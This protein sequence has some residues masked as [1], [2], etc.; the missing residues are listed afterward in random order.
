MEEME[1]YDGTVDGIGEK[2]DL[3]HDG[4]KDCEPYDDD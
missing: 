1:G 4:T 3:E 2:D